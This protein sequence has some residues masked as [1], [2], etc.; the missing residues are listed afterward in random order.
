[1]LELALLLAA[2]TENLLGVVKAFRND[3]P[4]IGGV[5]QEIESSVAGD[6][7]LPAALSHVV[8]IEATELNRVFSSLL[9]AADVEFLAALPALRGAIRRHVN[10]ICREMPALRRPSFRAVPLV[11]GGLNFGRAG[12]CGGPA[13]V[14]MA[15]LATFHP[16]VDNGHPR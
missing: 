5:L 8:R 6:L 11:A 13:A 14:T 16:I 2:P 1:M 10:Y 4:E 7:D 3:L 15:G 12:V 9:T